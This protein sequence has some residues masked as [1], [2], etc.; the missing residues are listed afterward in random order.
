MFE[1]GHARL[2]VA[3]IVAMAVHGL[4]FVGPAE[5]SESD[6][7]PSMQIELLAQ[8]RTSAVAHAK[9]LND[10]K[11]ATQKDVPTPP[12]L[13]AKKTEHKPTLHQQTVALS[14]LIPVQKAVVANIEKKAKPKTVLEVLNNT[15]P[16]Q[17]QQDGNDADRV[18][19]VDIQKKILTQVSYPMRARRQGWEGRAEFQVNVRNQDVQQVTMLLSTGHAMLDHAAQKGIVS[20]ASLPLSD[21][22]YRLPVVFR[23]Q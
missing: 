6:T 2:L 11:Q 19:P 21:G 22:S 8:P 17:E 16:T 12:N 13:I 4:L 23:L 5:Q 3:F 10:D 18:M 15:A 7:Y 9:P 20:I 14:K 1:S